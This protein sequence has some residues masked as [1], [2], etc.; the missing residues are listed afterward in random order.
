MSGV[1]QTIELH[2]PSIMGYEK[3]AME[4]AAAVAELMGFDA[5]RV[6][7]L[8][9]AVSEACVNAMEHG[10]RLQT[11]TRV[12]IALHMQK[13]R[14]EVDVADEGKG[15]K[16]KPRKPRIEAKVDGQEDVRGWGVFLI[17]NLVDEVE[18]KKIRRGGNVTRLV[19]HLNR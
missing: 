17:Q 16:K 4:S 7:D 5:A 13:E 1:K 14:L 6:E 19:I 12:L 15:F 10:N 8:K 3:I 18:F 9:T 2:L 11:D